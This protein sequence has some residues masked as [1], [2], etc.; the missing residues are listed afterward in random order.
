MEQRII[1]ALTIKN[2]V[3]FADDEPTKIHKNAEVL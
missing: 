3:T 1:W 2:A